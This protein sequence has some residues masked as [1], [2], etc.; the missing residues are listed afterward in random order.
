MQH[1]TRINPYLSDTEKKEF[2]TLRA[3]LG[4][5]AEDRKCILVTGV[6]D[7]ANAGDC[8]L[9]L[10]AALSG[11]G[12]RTLLMECDFRSGSLVKEFRSEQKIY[13]LTHYLA[14]VQP[15]EETICSTDQPRLHIL[16]AGVIPPNPAELLSMGRFTSVIRVLTSIYDAVIVHA[17]SE[18]GICDAALCSKFC[19]GVMFTVKAGITTASDVKKAQEQ[20]DMTKCAPLGV[21]LRK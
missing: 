9:K 8:A 6:G 18:N 12:K 20:F 15:I 11:I 5:S 2:E 19:D 16:F 7:D 17:P 4:F 1:V 14:G 3:K 21:I 10:A 13:G